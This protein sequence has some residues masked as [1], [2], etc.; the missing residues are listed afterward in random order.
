MRELA[1]RFK[2]LFNGAEN[3]YG[4]YGPLGPKDEKGKRVGN[5]YTRDGLVTVE[6]WEGHL[7]GKKMLGI[8]PIRED[9]TVWFG[10]ID[11]DKYGDELDHKKIARTLEKYS[12]KLVLT[13]SKS[14]GAHFWCFT[15][16]AV[17]AETMQKYLSGIAA[18]L[19]YGG[20]EI[21]PKQ[22][23]ILAERG[24]K[25][26]WIN[27]PYF[28][29]LNGM[30]FGIKTTGDAMSPEEFLDYA[31]RMRL[32]E[33]ELDKTF[34]GK[35]VEDFA[36]GPPCLQH[37]AQ[38]GIPEGMR[39]NGLFAIAVYLR[40]AF[41]DAWEDMIEDYNRKFLDP[42]LKSVEV[43]GLIKSA[44]K[45]DFCYPCSKPPIV[46][47]CNSAVCRTRKYGVQGTDDGFP[48]LGILSML[49]VKPP[50]WFWDVDGKRMEFTTSELRDPGAFQTKC[51]ETIRKVPSLPTKLMWDKILREAMANVTLI[52]APEDASNEGQFWEYVGKFCG[53]KAKALTLDEIILG[54]PFEDEHGAVFFRLVDLE[55]FLDKKK[56]RKFETNKVAALLKDR[57]AT[58]GSKRMKGKP[59]PYWKLP[60]REKQT[61]GFEVPESVKTEEAY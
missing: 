13:R 2:Q 22:T 26:N 11:V 45:K 41:P 50:L 44:K 17:P 27:M 46:Q 7:A 43:L 57:G 48:S 42:P 23:R 34:L 5:A 36:D 29:L 3:G 39:N 61:E 58:T 32:D 6:L 54:K 28:N 12:L 1:T 60:P 51:M 37:L 40:K 8:I 56:F 21:F 35:T 33:S 14:G 55:E 19:G 10:A 15:K 53:S 9:S 16:S 38:L 30:R 49:D 52:E 24:D 47:H 20:S 4:E 59:V 18:F 31:E 25:G